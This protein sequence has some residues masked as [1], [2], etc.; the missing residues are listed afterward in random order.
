M[1]IA[2]FNTTGMKGID[3]DQDHEQMDTPFHNYL[4]TDGANN[5]DGTGG[6]HGLGKG[7]PII[8]STMRTIFASTKHETG[9]LYQGRTTL[10]THLK[11]PENNT[12][13]YNH[14]KGYWGNENFLRNKNFTDR[15][16]IFFKR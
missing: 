2:D 14:Y 10:M 8:N 5:S 15:D 4:K 6:S 13:G 16:V 9:A 3:S 7:A 11:D 1:K 12:G